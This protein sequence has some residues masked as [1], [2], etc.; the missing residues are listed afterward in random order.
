MHIIVTVKFLIVTI[1]VASKPCYYG[2]SVGKRATHSLK[3]KMTP[4]DTP[5]SS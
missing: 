4:Y 5:E 2:K 3:P 1:E